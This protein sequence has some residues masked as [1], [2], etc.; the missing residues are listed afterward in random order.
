MLEKI[1]QYK[2]L[3]INFNP[4]IFTKVEDDWGTESK[5]TLLSS[6]NGFATPEDYRFALGALE[7]SFFNLYS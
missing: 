4:E 7:R 6:Y 2:D 1:E 5:L 3:I